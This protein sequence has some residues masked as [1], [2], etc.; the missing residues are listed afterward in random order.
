MTKNQGE[1]ILHTCNNYTR[2]QNYIHTIV[3]GMGIILSSWVHIT[4][5]LHSQLFHTDLTIGRRGSR[6]MIR[7][8]L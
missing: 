2:G 7:T 6:M 4:A 5:S 8:P 3:Y 1:E